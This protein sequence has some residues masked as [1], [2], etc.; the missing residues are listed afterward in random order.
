MTKIAKKIDGYEP[1]MDVRVNGKEVDPLIIQI[2]KKRQLESKEEIESFLQPKLADLPDPFL[3]K[4]MDKACQVTSEAIETGCQIIICGDYDVDGVS[5]TALLVDFFKTIGL[6]PKYDIPNR[7]K[8]G[9]G[10]N[11]NRLN[12]KY[13]FNSS[14]DHLIITVDNGI[15][16]NRDI[17][18]LK[19]AG[20]KVVITDHHQPGT[21]KVLAD[22]VL[23][24]NQL[25]CNFPDKELAGV[26]VAFYFIAGLRKELFDNNG[27]MA[28]QPRPNLKMFM[29]YVSLGT[30]GDLVP[31][32]GANRILTRSGL[33]IIQQRKGVAA[34]FREANI[35]PGDMVCSEDIGFQIGP[36]INAAGRLGKAEIACE[37]IMSSVRSSA[38]KLSKLLSQLNEERKGLCLEIYENVR[39]D[40]AD[41]VAEGR[42]IIVVRGD[43]HFGV[44]GIVA[45]RLVEQHGLPV[46]IFSEE[47]DNE[48]DVKLKGSGRSIDGVDLFELL[49]SCY[50]TINRYGGH[51]MAAGLTVDENRFD[52]FYEQINSKAGRF[53][54]NRAGTMDP[55]TIDADY[56]ILQLFKNSSL[57]SDLCMLEPHGPTN[58]QPI[59]RDTGAQVQAISGVGED[60]KHLKMV[61]GAGTNVIHGIGFGLGDKSKGFD[62]SRPCEVIYSLTMNR[63]RRPH[64][65][66]VRIHNIKHNN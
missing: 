7:L 5:G 64:Q 12:E 32:R 46:I 47:T 21:E 52:E 37:A 63:F 18:S 49:T 23:N 44:I 62:L 45:S 33:E 30:I 1:N 28:G 42:K 43:Y 6:S 24:P 34:L 22:A 57:I 8:D 61:F 41:E 9:Y 54:C 48:G 39:K 3:M 65:W 38:L 35:L 59:F 17:A 4:G 11:F 50:S 14:Q 55:D 58:P 16:A 10:L 29:D 66:Q 60:K 26:G 19:E 36:R 20:C 2:C 40:A 25:S 13:D 27:Q 31:M 56:S 15:S 53:D 51:A